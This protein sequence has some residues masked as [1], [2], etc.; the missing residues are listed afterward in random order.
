MVAVVDGGVKRCNATS[1]TGVDVA[2]PKVGGRS[3]RLCEARMHV[4]SAGRVRVKAAR[5][6]HGV[7]H[8]EEGAER[9]LHVC[10]IWTLKIPTYRGF[11][12]WRH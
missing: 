4:K 9:H 12:K 3:T 10:V 8:H 6:V 1:Q 11:L 7:V 2:M 5:H